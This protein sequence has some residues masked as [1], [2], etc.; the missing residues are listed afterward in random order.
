VDDSS[1]D[2]SGGGDIIS[3]SLYPLE[4]LAKGWL[5]DVDICL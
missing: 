2:N 1:T 4:Y 5:L 3:E